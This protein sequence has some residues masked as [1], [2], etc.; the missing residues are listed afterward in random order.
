ME[1]VFQ[2]EISSTEVL[3]QMSNMKDRTVVARFTENTG[4]YHL[5]SNLVGDA[6]LQVLPATEVV[7]MGC[8]RGNHEWHIT[9]ATPEAAE[10][11][12]AA[13][14]ITV[15]TAQGKRTAYLEPLQPRHV[16]VRVLWTPAWV[17]PQAVHEMLASIAVVSQFER[18]RCRLGE[19]AVHNLQYT[20][21]LHDVWP[22]KVPDRVTLKV[23]GERVPLL[24]LVRGKPRTCFLCGSLNHTQVNCPNP[25]CR[26]CKAQGHVVLNCP[27]KTQQGAEKHLQ[28]VQP[29]EG[30]ST[31]KETPQ[32]P[33]PKPPTSADAPPPAE[34]LSQPQATSAGLEPTSQPTD[35]S[36]T[37]KRKRADPPCEEEPP[38]T[39]KRRE[40]PAS[41]PETQEEF[42]P[43]PD[44]L[45]LLSIVEDDLHT[46]L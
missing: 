32:A 2:S 30:E 15:T 44:L 27:K 37:T 28:S 20:A 43:E 12:L 35:K 33:P 8:L 45:S 4:M 1:R 6:L 16:E 24:L 39:S 25:T 26:Y 14:R 31:P 34:S 9:L 21:L 22:V 7:A 41:I 17:P 29:Q 5:T 3:N 38:S 13:S 36:E 42:S 10:V 40:E 46:Q 11:L 19:Q 18:C 23:L